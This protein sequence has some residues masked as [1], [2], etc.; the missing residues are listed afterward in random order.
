MRQ[1]L[2]MPDH[3]PLNKVR[4]LDLQAELEQEFSKTEWR[5]AIEVE[6]ER[7]LDRGGVITKLASVGIY[8]RRRTG[9]YI[10]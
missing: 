9:R 6:R 3:V 1:P 2:A 7:F 4:A 8:R 10:D 5:R